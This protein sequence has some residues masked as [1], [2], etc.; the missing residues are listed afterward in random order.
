MNGFQIL[1]AILFIAEHLLDY[2]LTWLN[3]S[4]VRSKANEIP[5]YFR[6]R[7]SLEDYQ[8]SV[9][10][11]LDKAWLGV[12]SSL[13][14]IPILWSMILSGFFGT[15]DQWVRSWGFSSIPTGAIFLAIV[16][17]LFYA[18]ALPFNLY[19]VFVVEQKYGFNKMTFKLWLLDFVK[20]LLL[21][22]VIGVP[23]L[24]GVLWF[25]DRYGQS[26]WWFYVWILLAL[27]QFVITTVFPVLI[28][29]LFNKLTPL[30]AGSLRT[31]IEAIA[32]KVRFKMSGV[33]TMDGSRRS[34]HSN[35]YFAGMGR[36]RRIVLFDT[37]VRT[38]S[39]SE[40]VAV[41][42]HEM[43]HNQ[44]KHVRNG[45]LLG[46]G[47]S[48]LAL[49]VLSR[50]IHAPWFYEAFGFRAPSSYA[51]LFIFMK[52]SGPFTFFLEPLF[53]MLSRKHEYEADRFAAEVMG[54]QQPMIQGLVKLTQDNLSNLTPHPL[55]SF[56]YY[57]H[58]TVMERIAAL[59]N[60]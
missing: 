42:A 32:E 7:I 31:R 18:V 11:T 55:Y 21:S 33:F 4:Y 29:P 30:E 47:A 52:A 26:Y 15:V 46:L 48:F 22:I 39:E 28:V 45:L 3:V 53:S 59:E 20:G 24:S 34:T 25:M 44:K 5:S 19:S 58:P 17:A 2:G 54:T 23:V 10:Y 38:L 43:G 16:S 8:K 50:V 27:V 13:V 56:F 35:A 51:A 41:L 57:S 40:L 14:G 37:L 60:V 6:D 12:V 49:F 36:F 1:F 9:R